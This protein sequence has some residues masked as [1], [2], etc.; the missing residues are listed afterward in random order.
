MDGVHEKTGEIDSFGPPQFLQEEAVDLLPD[1]GQIPVAQS[2]PTSHATAAAHL[3]G[4]EFPRDT[5][6]EDKEDARQRL[7]VGE[8][9]SPALGMRGSGGDERLN[10]LPQRIREEGFSHRTA[11]LKKVTFDRALFY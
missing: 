11:L 7:A 6:L 2:A 5:A 9:W 4:Q 3:L 1:A 8:G 10:A